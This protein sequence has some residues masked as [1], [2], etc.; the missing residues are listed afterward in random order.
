MSVKNNSRRIA[1]YNRRHITETALGLFCC[2]GIFRATV[3]EIASAG[4]ISKVTVYHYFPTKVDIVISVMSE[5]MKRYTDEEGRLLFFSDGYEKIN[6]LGQIER[7]LD[8]Y[9]G[10][11]DDSMDYLAFICELEIYIH[12]NQ[13]THQ[14][15]K[16][17]KSRLKEVGVYFYDAI[18]KG[19][20]DGSIKFGTHDAEETY[21]IL[22]G[23][24]RGMCLNVFLARQSGKKSEMKKAKTHFETVM[25]CIRSLLGENAGKGTHL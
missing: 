15:E 17:L 19:Y 4:D 21:E 11:C 13:L 3:E 14:Q 8:M 18:M 22:R 23:M 10:L 25:Q 20:A 1:D 12:I 16:L 2:K 7:I 5:I 24:L 6:G 9:S